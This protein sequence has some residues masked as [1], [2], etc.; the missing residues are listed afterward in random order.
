MDKSNLICG[1]PP[2]PLL[3]DLSHLCYTD[4]SLSGDYESGAGFAIFQHKTTYWT[5]YQGE[6]ETHIEAK[7][8]YDTY[9]SYYLYQSPICSAELFAIGKAS[10]YILDNLDRLKVR[11]L[12]FMV[13]SQ[14]ALQK[15]FAPFITSKLVL[16]T[17]QKI[18]LLSW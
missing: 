7:P 18:N 16:Q 4:G 6:R 2:D 3:S 13:D 1:Y 5:N 8:L 17:K 14:G 11:N 10:D 9:R 12:A 15:L